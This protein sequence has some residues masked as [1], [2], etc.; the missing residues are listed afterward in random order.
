MEKNRVRW[1][2]LGCSGIGK[3]RTIPAMLSTSNAELYAIAGRNEEKLKAYAEPFAP[4]K[5][6]T[7]YQALLNDENVDAV[8]VP[9][10]NGLHMEWAIKAAEAGKHI[11]CEKPL[12]M[13]EEQVKKMFAAAKSNHV[14][15]EE[16]YAAAPFVRLLGRNQPADTKNV[17]R[18]NCV[19]IGWAYDPRTN[20]VI[21]MSAEDNVV[22]GAGG[23]AVQSFNIMCG[24]DETEGLWVL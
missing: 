13:N 18:T 23:Q 1:G 17:T 12:A 20:R 21:L 24:F 7:D 6:Y 11:L 2:V 3:N 9:L 8:Y 4:K 14:L 22:K 10:P 15:L 19:D 5:L 16:A